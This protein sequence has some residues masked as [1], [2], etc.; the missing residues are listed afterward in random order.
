MISTNTLSVF[1]LHHHQNVIC[2]K[3][4]R[5]IQEIMRTIKPD[6]RKYKNVC[7]GLPNLA[8]LTKSA[9]PGEVQLK[10]SHASIGY[11]SLGE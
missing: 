7:D 8:V 4:F 2:N 1:I 10:F 9:T 6:E 5:S 3:N 11:K